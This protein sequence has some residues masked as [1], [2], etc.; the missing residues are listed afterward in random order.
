MFPSAQ[1]V[2]DGLALDRVRWVG[3]SMGGATGMYAAATTLKDRITH[4][5]VNDIGPSLPQPA[6][7]RILAYAGNPP[8]FD[9]D[10]W[11]PRR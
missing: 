2:V 8:A 5:V 4:L 9:T 10:H 11:D 1:E 3:T 6:I 7:D